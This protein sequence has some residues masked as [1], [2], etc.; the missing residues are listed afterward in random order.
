MN[1]AIK[2]LIP[3]GKIKRPSYSLIANWIKE[4]WDAIDPDM[5]MRSFKCCGISNAMG[6]L[7]F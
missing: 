2:E 5:I 7:N 1:E 6:Q 3:T 4:S